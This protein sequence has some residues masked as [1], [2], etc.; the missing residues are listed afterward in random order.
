MH[1]TRSLLK[2]PASYKSTASEKITSQPLGDRAHAPLG[3]SISPTHYIRPVPPT[4]VTEYEAAYTTPPTDAYVLA[5]PSHTPSSKR[6][7]VEVTKLAAERVSKPTNDESVETDWGNAD[8][9]CGS[10]WMDMY[11]I[12]E[13]LFNLGYEKS[14]IGPILPLIRQRKVLDSS[15]EFLYQHVLLN[16][17]YEVLGEKQRKMLELL[18]SFT[19]CVEEIKNT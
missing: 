12:L 18:K 1:S 8:H 5:S 17:D 9:A 15:I 19:S 11:F 14:L 7:G 2:S 13:E 10:Q 3:H 16:Q 4:Y 6:K